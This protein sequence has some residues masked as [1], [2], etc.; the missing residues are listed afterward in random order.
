MKNAIQ[1]DEIENRFQFKRGY[2][3][4]KNLSR[5]IFVNFKYALIILLKFTDIVILRMVIRSVYF[6]KSKNMDYENVCSIA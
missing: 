6:S 5:E 2:V 4:D 3:L 1:E